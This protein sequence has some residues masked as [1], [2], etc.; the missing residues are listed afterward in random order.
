MKIA[1]RRVVSVL[2]D[3]P[4]PAT[5]GLHLRMIGNLRALHALG[6]DSS[7]LWFSTPDRTP[8]V[9]DVDELLSIVSQVDHV[10]RRVEQH[11]LPRRTRLAAKL[12][13]VATGLTGWP[14]RQYPF[15][16]RYD[17]VSGADLVA[18]RLE[19][20]GAS[21]VVLPSQLMHWSDR[22]RR[23]CPGVLVVADAAD[24]LTDVTRRL[25][26]TSTGSWLSRLGLW[27][28]HLACRQHERRYFGRV[29]EVWATTAAE[30]DRVRALAPL[31]KVVVVA[32]T[33]AARSADVEAP[34]RAPQIPTTT[35]VFGMMATWSYRPNRDAA[36]RLIETIGPLIVRQ[37]PDA[38]LVLAGADL[39]ADLI[40]RA[41]DA[42]FVD[43]MGPVD[44]I[45]LF[46]DAVDVVALPLEVRGGVPLKLAEALAWG[47]P[48]VSTPELVAG[49]DLVDGRDVVVGHDDVALA[50][51]VVELLTNSDRAD[52][53]A[54]AGRRAHQRL[55]SAS[56]IEDALLVHSVVVHSVASHSL[57]S[58]S[59]VSS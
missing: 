34:A 28:N 52:E 38:R 57:A 1:S 31:A 42:G 53:V 45:E 8:D 3:F 54:T 24:V 14:G 15:A 58:H 12:G 17:A 11:D 40:G 37:C 43:V 51:R 7:V 22:I 59:A 46:Y 35:P 56:T 50:A 23:S 30:A 36:A 6:C 41:S 20:D 2:M 55:F 10:G 9:V 13:F 16:L 21:V 27:A 32:N 25:A 19:H 26:A 49:L 47:R 44:H 5:T 33:V 39:P 18:E 48:V 29:D 4:L